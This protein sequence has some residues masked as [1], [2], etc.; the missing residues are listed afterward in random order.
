MAE[1]EVTTAAAAAEAAEEEAT[2][3]I[4]SDDKIKVED[5]ETDEEQKPAISI[6]PP[7]ETLAEQEE[8]NAI[9]NGVESC[10]EKEEEKSGQ[11]SDSPEAKRPRLEEETNGSGNIFCTWHCIDVLI[12]FFVYWELVIFM[13]GCF[14]TIDSM[15]L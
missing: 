15:C 12:G 4:P 14:R 8:P 13:W 2:I 10:I 9:S 3:P 7:D 1:E 11:L 5:L 6:P